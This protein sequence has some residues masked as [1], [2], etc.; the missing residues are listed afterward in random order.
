[1]TSIPKAPLRAVATP[2]LAVVLLCA[3]S[4]AQSAAIVRGP[5]LQNAAPRAITVRWRT[6]LPTD[7]RVWIGAVPG[8]YILAAWDPAAT[9]EHVV[10]VSG[11]TP[12]IRHYYAVGSSAGLLPGADSTWTFRTPPAAGAVRPARIWVLGDPGTPSGGQRRVRDAYLEFTAG[13][14]TDVWILLG[15]NA[16]ESGS[17]SDY[18]RGFFEPFATFL[19]GHAAWS[20]RGNHDDLRSGPANDYYDLFTFPTAGEAGGVPSGTEAWYSFDH[21]D[22]HF[23]CLDTEGLSIDPGTPMLNWLEA[24]LAATTRTWVIVFAHRPPYSKGSHD[25]DDEEAM[26]EMRENVMPILEAHGVDLVLAGHSHAYERSFLIDGHYGPSNT[27]ASSMILDGGDGDALGD[28]DYR[29]PQGSPGPHQ[30]EVVVVAGAS[31]SLA[32]GDLDHPIMARSLAV[33]GSLVI[34]VNGGLMDVRYL[35]DFGVVRDRFAIRK[36]A[37]VDSGPTA[38]GRLALHV[39]NPVHRAGASFTVVLPAAGRATLGLFD[40]H[41]RRV[42]SLAL[43]ADAAG[44]HGLR[45]DGS[46]AA[47][48]PVRAGVYFAV[49]AFAGERR[50]ARVVLVP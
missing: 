38:G 43:E 35:D 24:D 15:D 49:V 50:V 6:D 2:L 25:S 34:D 46:D 48:R 28:G 42:R 16:Y 10:R 22:V 5:Y 4:Q 39:P 14:E 13:H 20:T 27:L 3:A 11:L 23:V 21:G 1:M 12:E 8:E 31:S 40:V 41:G 47:G 32:G 26:I 33:L 9:T 37:V 29:K 30:G 18:E 7:S 36:G 19:R 17:D 44:P 45:W